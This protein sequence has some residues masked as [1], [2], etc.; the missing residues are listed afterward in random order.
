MCGEKYF[1]SWSGGKDSYL[2]LL[3]A[4]RAKKNV[5]ALLA[6]IS[7]EGTSMS[8]GLP[9][10]LLKRQALALELPLITKTVSW[11]KYEEGFLHAARELKTKGFSGGIFGDINIEAHRLWVENACAKTGIKPLFPLWGMEEKTV[12]AEL[13]EEEAELLVV[14]LRP[15]LVDPKWLG[16]ILNQTFIRELGGKKISPCGEKGEYHTFA[17]YGPFFKEKVPVIFSG[18]REKD[19]VLF[20]DYLC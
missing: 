16:Q 20:L 6:F 8:H 14:A 10:R 7:E 2:S 3:K 13:L 19:N 17:L 5:A 11:E 15:D 4:R 9:R 12:I 1:I 18:L